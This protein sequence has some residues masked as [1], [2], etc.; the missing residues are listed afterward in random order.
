MQE[1]KTPNQKS[2]EYKEKVSEIQLEETK[3]ASLREEIKDI[4]S[5]IIE[6]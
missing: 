1:E 6:L 2:R 3:A 5:Q 4:K